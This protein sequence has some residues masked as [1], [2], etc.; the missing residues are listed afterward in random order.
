MLVVKNLSANAGELRDTGSTL[1]LGRSLGGGHGNPLHYSCLENPIGRGAW[2]A[3]V[4][5]IAKSWTRQK[6]LSMQALSHKYLYVNVHSSIIHSSDTK[7]GNNS[8]VLQLMN[9]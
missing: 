4:H 7:G 3:T 9:G 1:G 2:W 5:R 8:N 6:R